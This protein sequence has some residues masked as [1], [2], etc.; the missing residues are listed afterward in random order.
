MREHTAFVGRLSFLI[1][2]RYLISL[3]LCL[4]TA[5][6]PISAQTVVF[7]WAKPGSLTPAFESPTSANRYGPYIGDAIFTSPEGVTFDIDDSQVMEL[8][9][10]ARFLY[11]YLTEEVELRV[12]PNSTI[13]ISAPEG[14]TIQTISFK[15]AKADDSYLIYKGVSGTFKGN[16]WTSSESKVSTVEFDVF[17][18]I[19]CTSTT[20]VIGDVADVNDIIADQES[21]FWFG[22]DGNRYQCRPTIPGVYIRSSNGK[23]TK[24]L[25]L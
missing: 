5:I 22:I 10:K 16:T 15:G 19:N 20:V 21:E 24:I 3:F 13:I 2:M 4:L 8:S 1:Y 12:Y 25:I 18:T 11:G 23:S 17:A 6:I 7:N 14:K 9:Q